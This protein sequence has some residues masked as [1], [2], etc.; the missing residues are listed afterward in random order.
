MREHNYYVY[1]VS[2]NNKRA[3]YI[4]VTS[5]LEKRI[6]ERKHKLIKGFTS[7]YNCNKLVYYEDYNDTWIAISR[8]KQLK[9]WVRRKK[10]RLIKK[11]NPGWQDLSD[12]WY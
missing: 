6:Y 8:E 12:G 4:G 3:I 11:M 7:K 9:K 2:S 5:N 10:D 1:I